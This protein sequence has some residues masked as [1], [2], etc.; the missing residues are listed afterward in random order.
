MSSSRRSSGSR[1]TTAA[2]CSNRS[3]TFRRPSSRR[4]TMTVRLL[5]SAWRFSRNELSGKPGAVQLLATGLALFVPV[6]TDNAGS[7]TAYAGGAA[8]HEPECGSPVRRERVL[9]RDFPEHI[10]SRSG[11]SECYLFLGAYGA[12]GSP[13]H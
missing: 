11:G 8:N 4:P 6:L 5:Q 2:A 3:A 10:E 13:E 12:P 1:G 7:V 9:V